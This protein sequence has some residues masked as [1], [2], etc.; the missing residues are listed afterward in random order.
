MRE[1]GLGDRPYG[2][3]VAAPELG[4]GRRSWGSAAYGNL[5]KFRRRRSWPGGWLGPWGIAPERSL[6]STFRSADSL[7]VEHEVAPLRRRGPNPA[8]RAKSVG[9][10]RRSTSGRLANRFGEGARVGGPGRRDHGASHAPMPET[11]EC[12]RDQELHTSLG[13]RGGR[14]A[15]RTP[16]TDPPADRRRE[17]ATDWSNAKGRD[18][19][20]RRQLHDRDHRVHTRP[21]WR[22]WRAPRD[23]VRDS[24]LRPTCIAC[25]A[26]AHTLGGPPRG[27]TKFKVHPLARWSDLYPGPVHVQSW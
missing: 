12:A 27:E 21:C 17:D 20:L 3:L 9:R 13:D 7:A 1:T 16:H 26:V 10:L 23:R 19:R 15:R 4:V 11:M 6:L 18:H 2:A 25:A 22:P 5:S 14:R 24:M 8:P